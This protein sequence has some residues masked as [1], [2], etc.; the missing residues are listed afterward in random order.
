VVSK[1]RTIQNSGD[2]DALGQNFPNPFTQ[3]TYI[4]FY[5]S[6]D[7]SVEL[8]VFNQLG[9]VIDILV[10][11]TRKAGA[12]TIELNRN[13]PAGNYYYQLTTSKITDTK[14]FSVN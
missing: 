7:G 8:K 4:P 5:L 12:Y 1:L 9:E 2:T 6:E 13:L 11:D 3:I 10:N 14:P